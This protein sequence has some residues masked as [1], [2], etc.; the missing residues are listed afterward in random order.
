M[1]RTSRQ[2]APSTDNWQVNGAG[3]RVSHDHGF[4]GIDAQGIFFY[5][6]NKIYNFF[7]K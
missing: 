5:R 6:W 3:L 7:F 2:M 1:A 4:G